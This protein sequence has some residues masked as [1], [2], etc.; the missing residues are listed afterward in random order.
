MPSITNSGPLNE[1]DQKPD[2][3]PGDGD[4]TG[5]PV[6]EETPSAGTSSSTSGR[7]PGKSGP[8]GTPGRPSPAPDAESLSDKDQQA[9]TQPYSSASSTDGSTQG[10][11]PSPARQPGSSAGFRLPT[12][13]TQDPAPSSDKAEAEEAPGDATDPVEGSPEPDDPGAGLSEA[14]AAAEAQHLLASAH[15]AFG[16]KDYDLAEGLLD[17]AEEIWPE[18]RSETAQ[19]RQVIAERRAES[20]N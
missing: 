20:K 13:V 18:I 11:G 14:E 3:T 8:S 5:A 10:T 19:P 12:P 6:K 4:D 7:K 9:S 15:E 16:K 17:Q 2:D 1:L